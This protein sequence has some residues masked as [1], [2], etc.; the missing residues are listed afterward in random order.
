MAGFKECE[1]IAYGPA[2]STVG[3]QVMWLALS[4]VPLLRSVATDSD[5]LASLEEFDPT[6]VPVGTVRLSAIRMTT[7]ANAVILIQALPQGQLAVRNKKFGVLIRR[8]R[9]DV[10]RDPVFL[11]GRE[12]LAITDGDYVF[13]SNRPAFQTLFGLLEEIQAQAASTFQ[14]ITEKLEIE[15]IDTMLGSGYEAQRCLAK[16]QV[17]NES[18][19]PIQRTSRR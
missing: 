13:F 14:E 11:L 4:A 17:F 18:W 9:I 12:I 10:P 7:G 15:G 19:R 16:W 3:E 8:G 5:D 6:E 1:V 2:S